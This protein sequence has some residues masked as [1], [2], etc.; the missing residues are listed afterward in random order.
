MQRD[1]VHIA[2]DHD[3]LAAVEGGFAGAGEVEHGRA[4][5]EE[6][7]LGRVQV[8]RLGFG[9]ERAGAE[10]ND[11]RLG[12]ENGNG[13]A[14]AEA[15]V[16]GAPVVG[17]DEK[18]GLKELRLAESLLQERR[19]ERILR[20]RRKADA[21]LLQGIARQSPLLGIEQRLAPFA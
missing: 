16:S 4:L 15:I 8:F 11:A 14:V 3:Q 7:R 13:E 5:V 9:I 20:V 10:G 6:P 1:D 17:L 18:T 12:V 19:L 2:F 21:E